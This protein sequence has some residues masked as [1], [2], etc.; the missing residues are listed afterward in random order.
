VSLHYK[1]T[2]PEDDLYGSKHV[3][4]QEQKPMKA[5]VKG[6]G[7]TVSTP[8]KIETSTASRDERPD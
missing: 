4:L 7:A 3:V 1:Y 5:P 8:A 6:C 2:A